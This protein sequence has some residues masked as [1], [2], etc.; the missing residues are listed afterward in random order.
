[1][2][3]PSTKLLYRDTPGSSAIER[4]G[5]NPITQ[6]LHILFNKNGRY[7]EYIWGGVPKDIAAQFLLAGSKGKF[8]HARIK[9]RKQYKVKRAF[10]SYRLGAVGR[11]IGN[12]FRPGR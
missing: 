7:P 8:Y 5:W 11:R 4:V 3:L 1:M 9:G 6:E 2:A 12:I 10:G